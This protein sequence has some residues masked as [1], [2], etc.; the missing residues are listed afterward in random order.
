MEAGT[1]QDPVQAIPKKAQRAIESKEFGVTNALGTALRVPFNSRN[2]QLR[3]LVR[4]ITDE[5]I[6]TGDVS[7]KTLEDVFERAY[8]PNEQKLAEEFGVD[9]EEYRDNAER[10]FRAQVENLVAEIRLANR[11]AADQESGGTVAEKPIPTLEQLPQLYA[12]MKAARRVA[13]KAVARNL[14]TESDNAKVNRLLRGDIDESMLNPLTDNV[15][16]I[17]E[18]YRAKAEYEKYAR[19]IRR[20]NKQRKAKLIELSDKL[21]ETA[22]EWKDKKAG[23]MYSRETMERNIRDIVKDK[24]LAD[25]I[26]D[27][28]FKPVHDATA[29]ATRMK[30]EY[31]DRVRA[32][33]LSR[34]VAKGNEISEAAAVQLLGEAEDNIRYLQKNK[35]I[36]M[37]DG[38]T[39]ADWQGIVRDLW[40]SNPNLDAAKIRKS[41]DEFR[42]IYD[43][44]FEKMN[45]S[46]MRNG[47]EP[48]NYRKG[49]FPHFQAETG[50]S[51]LAQFGKSLGINTA[52][53]QLPTTINGLTHTF[54]PGIQWFGSAQQR[55]GVNTSFDA[56][57]GFD[58]YIEGVAD[59]IHQTDNIQRLRAFATQVRYRTSDEGLR[60]QV[61]AVRNDPTIA[62]ED[63]QNRIK[64]IFENG[65]YELGNF[66]VEL[67]EYTNLLAGKKSRHDRDMEQKL[68]RQMYSIMKAAESKVAANM[69][70]VNPGSWLTNFIPITQ[71][72]ATLDNASL[73]TGMWDTL[74]AYKQD[75]GMVAASSFLTNRRGSDP[76]VRTWA[77]ETS[78]VLSKPMELID[79]FTADTLVRA[80]YNQNIKRGMSEEAAI[81][82]ADEWAAGVMADRSKGATPTLFSQTNPVT[83]LFT[84]FQ[85]EVNNQLSYVFKDIPQEMQERGK[86]ALALAML[87]FMI[88]A[89]L[90]DEVYEYLIGRR[91]A[92]DPL[93][94]I[95][96]TVGDLTGYE[97]PNLVELGV[98]AV[99]GDM[100]SFQ[101]EKKG[102]YEAGTSVAT[103]V[104]E[105][106]PFVGGLLGGGRL[107]ISSA[108]PDVPKLWQAA[109]D[110]AWAPEKRIATAAKELAKP[111][112]YLIAPFGGGQV[113]KIAEGLDAVARGGSYSVNS[114]GEDILQYPIANDTFGQA[115]LNAMAAM[116]FGK[117]SLPA[118]R[119]WVES[120][121]DSLNANQTEL[122]ESLRNNGAG[123]QE[124]FDL[125]EGIEA[126]DTKIDKMVQ[127]GETQFDESLKELAMSN[128]MSFSQYEKYMAARAA[129]VSTEQYTKLLKALS[130]EAKAQKIE[131]QDGKPSTS[132][133]E[134]EMWAADL[135]PD[136]RRALWDSKGKLTD[137]Y[138]E[139]LK[140]YE[141]ETD[142]GAGSVN[143]KV[144]K[145]VLS[146]SKL[147]NL[148][149]RA[150]WN[151]YGWS[152]KSPW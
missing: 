108:L 119:E 79:S 17:L 21:L 122:F 106:L 130:E 131:N 11:Y 20:W 129:G 22:G 54:K 5:F 138:E 39:L 84:Q 142:I 99:G 36:K 65:K 28:L 34:K 95:N 88:G 89:Y 83:K 16:G 67:D 66:A 90:Y 71:G 51:I 52:A 104:L 68:G 15:A 91:P 62:E 112:A 82:E 117:S 146:K 48:V 152:T 113:K 115:G 126:L 133:I 7:E 13:D 31:R 76:L 72:A 102:L 2:E 105:E 123:T 70:A 92:L 57:E 143:Q 151:S 116:L 60:K 100:T 4:E 56:V 145:A 98:G 26:N 147:S 93:G 74:R 58:S 124:A 118:A 125:I 55:L 81:S 148:Q 86:K 30:N 47:Y 132:Q 44:L 33:G 149:K 139:L 101:V 73:L 3:G 53:T 97:L 50:D 140:K 43:E 87:K 69:V 14:L 6:R 150:I 61:D 77:Q 136:E 144:L 23:W 10:D 107:P 24:A 109:T 75:D 19:E 96:D 134:T 94:I 127:I 38:K 37:R 8:R 110:S 120:G 45:E 12:D 63:K 1:E 35:F 111:A 59:V 42:A 85:L 27:T 103:S 41:V 114:K 137:S 128:Q 32:L 135:T 46:R 80:R 141:G 49:Y 9:V 29:K 40:E 121:F 25:E 64:D 18:V 78:A